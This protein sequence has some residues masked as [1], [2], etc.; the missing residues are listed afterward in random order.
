MKQIYIAQ[1]LPNDLIEISNADISKGI[2]VRDA[3][4]KF[5]GVITF[6][7]NSSLDV[8]IRYPNGLC[9]NSYSNIRA[10]IAHYSTYNFY[11][12]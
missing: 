5:I 12:L 6:A 7:D 8:I 1:N 3:Q 9:H 10:L 11:Q 2:I 4:K